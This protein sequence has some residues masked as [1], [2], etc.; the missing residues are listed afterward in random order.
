MIGGEKKGKISHICTRKKKRVTTTGD[1]Q[2]RRGMKN[3]VG[4]VIQNKR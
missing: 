4:A 1:E 3:S 2:I